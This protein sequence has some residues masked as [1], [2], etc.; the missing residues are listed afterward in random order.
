LEYKGDDD[1]KMF[2]TKLEVVN[3]INCRCFPSSTWVSSLAFEVIN[4]SEPTLVGC[5]ISS[6]PYSKPPFNKL[7]TLPLFL[8]DGDEI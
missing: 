5:I 8:L 7:G 3:C 2:L 4:S 1:P 6:K